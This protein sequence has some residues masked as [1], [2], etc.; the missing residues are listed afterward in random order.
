MDIMIMEWRT[1]SLKISRFLAS[2][3]GLVFQRA[4]TYQ[5]EGAGEAS[6]FQG[7]SG[8]SHSQGGTV[9]L[10]LD[11]AAVFT[12]EVALPI[13]DR[14]KLRELLPLELKGETAIDSG[15]LVFDALPLAGGKVLALWTEQKGLSSRIMLLSGIGLE[16]R[17]AGCSMIH[18]HHLLPGPA[19]G[20][21]AI[22]DGRSLAVY[23]DG[24]PLLFRVIAGDDSLSGMADTLKILEYS[25]GSGVEKLYLHGEAAGWSLPDVQERIGNSACTILPVTDG[26][27]AAFP[28]EGAALE[29]AGAWALANA[30]R[31]GD[32]VNF[33][34]GSLAYTADRDRLKKKL[35]LTAILAGLLLAMLL[36]ETCLRYYLVARD[37]SSLNASIGRIYRD[38]F[39]ARKKA[40]DE[41]AE[42]KAEIRRM[43]GGVASADVLRVL[44]EIALAKGGDVTGIYEADIESGQVRLKGDARSFQAASEFKTRMAPL[45]GSA[46]MGEV[47]SKPDGSVS[48]S[49]TGV[50]REGGK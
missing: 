1:H 4:E 50:S 22:S 8:P 49:F 12:R 23:R 21:T 31:T 28:D 10:S 48:F 16:P 6:L 13:T 40:V 19:G 44:N 7:E 36:G 46:E 24:A 29:H 9:V 32:P 11:P 35:R 20:F 30:V 5:L 14:N 25:A 15:E 33:R 17:I 42:L 37:I 34:H 2:G 26:L 18:W 27:A 41:V 39:P 45:F 47:K 43:G 3:G 38:V